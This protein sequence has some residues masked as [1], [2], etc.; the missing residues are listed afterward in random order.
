MDEN[1]SEKRENAPRIKWQTSFGTLLV[2][3]EEQSRNMRR[4]ALD[5]T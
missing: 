1:R 5:A 3:G 4:T 2:K